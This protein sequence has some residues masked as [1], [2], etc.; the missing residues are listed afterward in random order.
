LT[1]YPYWGEE[2]YGLDYR[3]KVKNDAGT[4]QTM[5]KQR[6]KDWANARDKADECGP[7]NKIVKHGTT[8]V[9]ADGDDFIVDR[10]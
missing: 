4:V 1:K 9:T 6:T 5:I 8:I 7:E 3:D 10:N 2:Y